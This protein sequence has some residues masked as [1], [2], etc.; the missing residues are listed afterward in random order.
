MFDTKVIEA[1]CGVITWTITMLA[2]VII[3]AGWPPWFRR[4]DK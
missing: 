4:K 2:L 1:I 3:M